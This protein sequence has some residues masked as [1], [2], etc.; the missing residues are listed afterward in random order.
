MPSNNQMPT[1][2]LK[3][4]R[5]SRGNPLVE[6]LELDN[7]VFWGC[8][9]PFWCHPA[10]FRIALKAG[11]V[12]RFNTKPRCLWG[13]GHWGIAGAGASG[14]EQPAGKQQQELGVMGGGG[15][16]T[17]PKPSCSL[18]LENSLRN[19]PAG[20]ASWKPITG[21]SGTWKALGSPPSPAEQPLQLL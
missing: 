10:A 21:S 17:N 6:H 11:C 8:S 14:V 16:E 20:R 5:D 2:D 3:Q 9:R 4:S 13:A 18:R 12:L 19:D 15:A 1:R 7:D